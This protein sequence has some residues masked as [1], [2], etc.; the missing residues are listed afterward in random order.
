M[1]SSFSFHPTPPPPPFLLFS[2]CHTH[3]HTRRKHSQQILFSVTWLLSTNDEGRDDGE[4]RVD[5]GGHGGRHRRRRASATPQGPRFSQIH[6]PSLH[7]G[8]QTAALKIEAN[9]LR[10]SLRRRRFDQ[11]QPYHS[12]LLERRRLSIRHRR[13]LR[14]FQPRQTPRRQIQGSLS[15]C[16]YFST[17]ICMNLCASSFSLSSPEIARNSA[18]GALWLPAVVTASSCVVFVMT[19]V[20]LAFG[21]TFPF[22]LTVLPLI[23]LLSQ[24]Q[25]QWLFF[26]FGSPLTPDAELANLSILPLYFPFY[27]FLN[28]WPSTYWPISSYDLPC[29]IRFTVFFFPFSPFCFFCWIRGYIVICFFDLHLFS[30]CEILVTEMP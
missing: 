29:L 4:R 17:D 25:G 3:S 8:S 6:G 26:V 28:E 20:I 30:H 10:L 2:L 11:M 18:F 16:L 15:F 13:R 21:T 24:A 12:S 19:W 1:S 5:E 7:L 23:S 27:F 14:R 22:V 9:R